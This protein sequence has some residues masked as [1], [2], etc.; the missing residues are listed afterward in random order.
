[1]KE[2]P[3]LRRIKS[4]IAALEK[5]GG[6]VNLASIDHFIG[7]SFWCFFVFSILSLVLSILAFTG[8]RSRS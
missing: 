7:W 4:D 1:V 3:D 6:K 2:L 5:A 8:S